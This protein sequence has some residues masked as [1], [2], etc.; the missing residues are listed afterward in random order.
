[1]GTSHFINSTGCIWALERDFTTGRALF[2]GGRQR[3]GGGYNKLYL[4]VDENKRFQVLQRVMAQFD[5]VLNTTQRVALWN[6]LPDPPATFGY[7]DGETIATNAK[8]ELKMSTSTYSDFL[9]QCKAAGLLR[10]DES[11]K[12][13]KSPGLPK[14]TGVGT[15]QMGGNAEVA[16]VYQ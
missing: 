15:W 2:M 8:W 6:R 10:Q 16:E 9:K 13:S 3:A 7:N 4:V 12:Y 11:K 1:M 14:P 5:I